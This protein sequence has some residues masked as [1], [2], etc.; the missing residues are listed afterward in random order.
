MR[1]SG[2]A[3]E[4]R[5]GI[6]VF[7]G[8]LLVF[9]MSFRLEKFG[10]FSDKGYHLLVTIDNATG[11]DAKTPV[12]IAGVQVGK[13][14]KIAL[15]GYRAALTLSIL[16]SV[17]V[18]VDSKIAIKSQGMLGDKYIEI[19]PGKSGQHLAKGAKIQDVAQ[20][21]DMA[22]VLSNIDTAAKNFGE[23]MDG[24]KQVL[25]PSDQ[26]NLKKSFENIRVASGD[27]RQFLATNKDNMSG[28]VTSLNKIT[29]DVEQGKG[30]LGMLVK[31]DKLYIDAKDTVAS[32]KSI[33]GDVEQGK[34]T[35][36]KL[37]K[38]DTLYTDAKETLQNFKELTD[39]IK[40]GEGT[41]GKLA[42]DDGLYVEAEKAMKKIQK[43]AEGLQEMTPIT[44]LGTLVGIFF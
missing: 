4:I 7:L 44:V 32:L 25:G 1:K 42:K 12:F 31:D 24:L 30:T 38:D 20:M 41:L 35:I 28:I 34:G 21:A 15:D 14:A 6:V 23:T 29:T 37:V 3:T 19:I 9:Y 39:G 10:A 40:K 17:K 18:P 5:V 33:T 8:I 27:F 13:I 43:G 22:E 26:E 11:L 36:G 16:E 2:F